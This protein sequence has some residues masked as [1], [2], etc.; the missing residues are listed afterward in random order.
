LRL[1]EGMDFGV[2]GI[3]SSHYFSAAVGEVFPIDV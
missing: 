2:E 3:E 1:S